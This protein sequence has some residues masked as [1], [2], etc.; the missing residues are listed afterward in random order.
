MG[1]DRFQILTETQTTSDTFSLRGGPV[2]I[3][4]SDHAGGTWTLEIQNPDG[5]WVDIGEGAGGVSFD[6]NGLVYFYGMPWMS[7]RL[8]GGDDGAKAWIAYGD[9]IP[10]SGV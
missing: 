9:P 2:F 6:D 1:R 8:T 4:L 3:L 7:Y 5:D 10:G